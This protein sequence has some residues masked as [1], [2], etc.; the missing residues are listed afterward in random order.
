MTPKKAGLATIVGPGG[1]TKKFDTCTCI[2]CNKVW[3]TFSTEKG[4]GNPGGWCRMCMRMICPNCAGK[5]CEPFMRKLEKME[6]KSNMVV[7]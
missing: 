5:E 6:R 4:I 3:V 2:H 7:G 1:L